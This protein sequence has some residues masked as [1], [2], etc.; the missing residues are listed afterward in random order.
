MRIAVTSQNFRSVTGHAG[1]ARRF[2]VFEANGR[3]SPREIERLDLDAG[4]TIHG[5]DPRSKHPLDSMNVLITGGSGEGF[6]RHMAARGVRVVATAESDPALAVDAFLAG[7]VM[8]AS[9]HGHHDQA[10]NGDGCHDQA[11]GQANAC[12]CQT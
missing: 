8:S 10:E 6:I 12:S 4:M 11:A 2:I 5:F 7:R 3:D 1:R 9:S